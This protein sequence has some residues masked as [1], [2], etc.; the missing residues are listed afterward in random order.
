MVD[1]VIFSYYPQDTIAQCPELQ[2]Y[3]LRSDV[4]YACKYV[5]MYDSDIVQTCLYKYT[6]AALISKYYPMVSFTAGSVIV[7][8]ASGGGKAWG[9]LIPDKE[10]MLNSLVS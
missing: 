2:S 4:M 3:L 7:R 9:Y 8:M 10:D 5:S 6:R 1:T